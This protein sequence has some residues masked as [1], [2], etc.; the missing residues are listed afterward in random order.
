MTR[1]S[2]MSRGI[3]QVRVLLISRMMM[4]TRVHSW[5]TPRDGSRE[6]IQLTPTKNYGVS[7]AKE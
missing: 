7:A 5:R 2:S 6:I 1:S 4:I 3:W